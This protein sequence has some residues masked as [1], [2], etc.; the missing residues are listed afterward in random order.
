MCPMHCCELG[1]SHTLSEV[2]LGSLWSPC[3]PLPGSG[4]FQLELLMLP[5]AG[6][7]EVC[8]QPERMAVVRPAA[9]VRGTAKAT[10]VGFMEVSHGY[11]SGV[12]N[13]LQ[14]PWKMLVSLYSQTK[15]H[16]LASC[17]GKSPTKYTWHK[18][19]DLACMGTAVMRNLE[20]CILFLLRRINPK[21][22][23]LQFVCAFLPKQSWKTIDEVVKFWLPQTWRHMHQPLRYIITEYRHQIS[24]SEND[25][26]LMF[27]TE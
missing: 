1:T 11:E 8:R 17:E 25:K 7:G 3:L 2:W 6:E 4:R 10:T 27:C 26:I 19:V 5:A 20:Q 18:Q 13:P 22:W 9:A 23:Q 21:L 12:S 16:G 15:W 14:T 24:F